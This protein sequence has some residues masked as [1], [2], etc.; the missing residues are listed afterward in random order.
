MI[1]DQLLSGESKSR[2]V[3]I[4]VYLL[5]KTTLQTLNFGTQANYAYNMIHL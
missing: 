4:D 5:F 2:A 3:N 1:H